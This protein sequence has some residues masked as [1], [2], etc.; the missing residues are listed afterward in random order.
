MAFGCPGIPYSG[1]NRLVYSLSETASMRQ[2]VKHL[3]SGKQLAWIP[4]VCRTTRL[5]AVSEQRWALRE[6][7]AKNR[8]FLEKNWF[9]PGK[10]PL[11]G[12]GRG[13]AIK[14]TC[15]QVIKFSIAWLS[16]SYKI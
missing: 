14:E 12:G 9:P 5:W 6:E 4:H 7:L 10:N 16:D 13:R 1:K 15:L 11:K 8:E 3:S 2:L